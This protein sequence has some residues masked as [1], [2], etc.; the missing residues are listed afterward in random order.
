MRFGLSDQTISMLIATFKKYPQIDR[1]QVFGSRAIGNY[2]EN[3]DIDLVLWGN[4]DDLLL[5]KIYQQLDELPLPYKFDL[6]SYNEIN[7]D[8]L[9]THIAQ[10]GIDL[11]QRQSSKL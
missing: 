5:G 10:Y 8:A 3:S 11:Y 4:I 2:R 9:R 1:V 6:K 7:H